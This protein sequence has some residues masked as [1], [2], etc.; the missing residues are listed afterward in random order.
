MLFFVSDFV[1]S[2]VLG[3]SVEGEKNKPVIIVQALYL[4]FEDLKQSKSDGL[5]CGGVGEGGKKEE[6]LGRGRGGGNI[7]CFEFGHVS[8]SI[9]VL[10]VV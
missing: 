9:C 10:K 8:V 1:T 6:G 5:G 2:S 7:L 3:R 4:D